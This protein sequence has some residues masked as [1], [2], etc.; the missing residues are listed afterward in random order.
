MFDIAHT[1]PQAMTP[2]YKSK[3]YERR[4]LW[5]LEKGTCLCKQ[6]CVASH[7]AG[8]KLDAEDVNKHSI[9]E[10]ATQS[11]WLSET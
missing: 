1:Q 8:H 6:E 3:E 7:L 4:G 11:D 2:T 9:P 5:Q 10:T